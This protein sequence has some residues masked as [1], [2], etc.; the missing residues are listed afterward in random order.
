MKLLAIVIFILTIFVAWCSSIENQVSQQIELSNKLIQ[1]KQAIIDT[2]QAEKRKQEQIANAGKLYLEALNS[3]IKQEVK[4]EVKDEKATFI[5][6][7][8]W[9]TMENE[10]VDS[11][12]NY[13][14]IED[15][16][17]FDGYKACYV[18]H[19]DDANCFKK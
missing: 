6:T 4:E 1:E 16:G 2:A 10:I 5:C 7:L 12:S 15:C 11:I 14:F 9:E 18:R 19:S 17:A 8:D 3:G 13:E